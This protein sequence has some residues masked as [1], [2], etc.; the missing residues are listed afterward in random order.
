M[1]VCVRYAGCRRYLSLWRYVAD[2][3]AATSLCLCGSMCQI[4]WLPHIYVCMEVCVRYSGCLMSLFIWRYVTDTL[5][6]T[7]HRSLSLWRNVSGTLAATYHRY[8]PLSSCVPDMLAGILIYLCEGMRQIHWLPQV[9]VSMEVCV[10]HAGC[11]RPQ[12]SVS[13]EVCIRYA[14]CHIYLSLWRY[15][16]V[17]LD[18]T[19]HKSLSMG[20]CVRCAGCHRPQVSVSME[21]CVRHAD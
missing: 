13:M 8:L 21:V 6:A 7:D 18:A 20:V 15:V 19:D 9:Y 3:L 10:R 5:A 17:T 4:H 2:T 11:H 16:S 12:V 1:D 14:N